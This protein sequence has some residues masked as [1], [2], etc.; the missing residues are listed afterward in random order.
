MGS[1]FLKKRYKQPFHPS[2]VNKVIMLNPRY[3]ILSCLLLAS[4]FLQG[5]TSSTI[6]II[7]NAAVGYTFGK[8]INCTLGFGVSLLDYQIGKANAYSG[9]DVSFTVFTHKKDIYKEGLYRTIAVNLL[10]VVNEMAIVKLGVTKTKFKWGV[11][12]VNTIRSSWGPNIDLAFKPVEY[13]PAVGFRYFTLNNAC[14]GIGQS[15]PTFLYVGYQYPILISGT[16]KKKE[17]KPL[18]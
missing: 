5:Q 4:V 11:N 9:L 12:K 3:L 7:P 8:G 17:T 1:I 2:P 14:M 6:R 18:F 10:N 16:E 15:N 13:G